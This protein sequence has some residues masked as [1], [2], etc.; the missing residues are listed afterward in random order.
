LAQAD[1]AKKMS[2]VDS[3][4]SGNYHNQA[5]QG[6][7]SALSSMMARHAAYTG[8]EVSYDAIAA[9]GERWED[10]IDLNQFA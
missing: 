4:L 1:P 9:S 7:E 3:I 8:E 10:A 6:V 2:F 5:A